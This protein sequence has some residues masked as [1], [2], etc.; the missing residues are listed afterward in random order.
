MKT[1]RALIIGFAA[2]V[3]GACHSAKPRLPETRSA[4][5][6]VFTDSLLHSELCAPLKVGEDWRKLCTPKDQRLELRKPQPERQPP[7]VP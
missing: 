2:A 7:R 4:D 3:V 6:T 1:E 5:R